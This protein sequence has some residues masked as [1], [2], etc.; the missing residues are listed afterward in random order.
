MRDE[1]RGWTEVRAMR[2]QVCCVR[3]ITHEGREVRPNPRNAGRGD[4][5]SGMEEGVVNTASGSSVI[6]RGEYTFTYTGR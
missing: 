6:P 2:E 3:I 4:S 5:A 1:G